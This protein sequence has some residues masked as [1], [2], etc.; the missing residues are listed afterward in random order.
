MQ[1]IN[2]PGVTPVNDNQSRVTS[3]YI[4]SITSDLQLSVQVLAIS[5][6]LYPVSTNYSNYIPTLKHI[7][8]K[9]DK[10]ENETLQVNEGV[11]GG[12]IHVGLGRGEGGQQRKGAGIGGSGQVGVYNPVQYPHH[13]AMPRYSKRFEFF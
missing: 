1:T 9:R 12:Q 8:L 3:I 6:Y 5:R 11:I 4:V 7:C 10:R 2:A 13:H